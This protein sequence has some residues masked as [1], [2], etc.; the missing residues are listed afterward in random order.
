ME[1]FGDGGDLLVVEAVDDEVV[2]DEP[3]EGVFEGK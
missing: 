1:E 2:R 3:D